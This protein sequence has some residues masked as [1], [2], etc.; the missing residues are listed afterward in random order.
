MYLQTSDIFYNLK[1]GFKWL[2]FYLIFPFITV[3]IVNGPGTSLIGIIFSYIAVV[4]LLFILKSGIV[5]K[6]KSLDLSEVLINLALE[7]ADGEHHDNIV[8]AVK[9]S[10]IAI[11]AL[12]VILSFVLMLKLYS[13]AS[14]LSASLTVFL[15]LL[16]HAYY[17]SIAFIFIKYES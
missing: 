10:R 15:M 11:L 13:F 4:P 16:L 3:S 7:K 9:I 17:V 6:E 12:L 1:N 2:F 14:I 5:V 8:K